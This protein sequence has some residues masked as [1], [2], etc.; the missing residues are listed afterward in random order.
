[1]IQNDEATHAGDKRHS[2]GSVDDYGALKSVLEYVN[3]KDRTLVDG[4]AGESVGDIQV[5]PAHQ[6]VDRKNPASGGT[7]CLGAEAQ[8]ASKVGRDVVKASVKVKSHNGKARH[9]EKVPNG[10][11]QPV[12]KQPKLKSQA[13]E[14][15]PQEKDPPT[16]RPSV[17]KSLPKGK[18]A[19]EKAPAKAGL[20]GIYRTPSERVSR[21]ETRPGQINP[22]RET[23]NFPR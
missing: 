22:L 14:K 4:A 15:D 18:V 20:P 2:A 12:S 8:N 19:K 6:P 17:A 16:K 11:A 3:E 13:K 21:R 5:E 23:P 1:M 10:K 7:T 9:T